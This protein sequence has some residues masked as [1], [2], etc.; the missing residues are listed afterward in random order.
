MANKPE[1]PHIM[2]RVLDAV[3]LPDWRHPT[4]AHAQRHRL[5][6]GVSCLWKKI[7]RFLG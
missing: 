1:P 7:E 6:E 4:L 5:P 2:Q 3:R